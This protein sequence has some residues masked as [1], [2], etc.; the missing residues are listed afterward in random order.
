MKKASIFVLTSLL[1]LPLF[2][3]GLR[4]EGA[5]IRL[6]NSTYLRIGDPTDGDLTN[7]S[8]T[9]TNFGNL[10]VEGD[11]ANDGTII[12]GSD[13]VSYGEILVD[14]SVTGAGTS[15]AQRY[16]WDQT[17]NGTK[18]SGRWFYITPSVAGAN[19]SDLLTG[20]TFAT[21]YDYDESGAAW[22]KITTSVALDDLRG[23]A[24]RVDSDQTIGFQGTGFHQGT[25]S[26]ALTS[27][28]DGWNLIGNPYPVSIDADAS[29]TRN[30]GLVNEVFWVRTNK[31]FAT[32]NCLSDVSTNGGSN[33]VA[34]MQA[35]W[36]DCTVP[37]NFEFQN[38]D[39]VGSQPAFLK[40]VEVEEDLPFVRIALSNDD[41]G[42]EVVFAVFP[43]AE[44]GLDK[45]DTPK[46]YGAAS[47]EHCFLPAG[48]GALT[49]HAVPALPV[50]AVYPMEIIIQEAGEYAFRVTEFRG[51][52]SDARLF[53]EDRLTGTVTEIGEEAGYSFASEQTRTSGRFLLRVE[54]GIASGEVPLK[55]KEPRV[56]LAGDHLLLTDL[57]E[58]GSR[59]L[60]VVDLYGRILLHTE[61]EP[62]PEIRVP[63]PPVAMD[64]VYVVE[65][66][67]SG[68]R[69]SDKIAIFGTR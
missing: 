47:A 24:T 11:L 29:V 37:G 67:G 52:P 25:L 69:M 62:G 68:I 28:T 64:G 59:Q 27:D 46:K 36:V 43:E 48:G 23:Y 18:A 50:S 20:P 54:T 38:S 45:Y 66:S 5:E 57:P 9:L 10:I 30:M 40:T 22:N 13:V 3:Q 32:H 7:S 21:L 12:N 51:F 26:I 16:Y 58:T 56:L 55:S 17:D 34:P 49:V 53:L 15:I 1:C 42:D 39:K 33:V 65:I 19:S 4:N 14:G 63:L 6:E 41:R 60:K 31:Q 61:L 8:G 44:E 35:C 2:A